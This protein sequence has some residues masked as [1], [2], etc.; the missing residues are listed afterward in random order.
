MGYRDIYTDNVSEETGKYECPRCSY[1]NVHKGDKFCA[2]CGAYIEWKDGSPATF[3]DCDICHG[4][5]LYEHNFVD[6]IDNRDKISYKA[7]QMAGYEH[8]CD[9]CYRAATYVDWKAAIKEILESRT[10]RNRWKD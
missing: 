7:L 1:K 6:L 2:E 3:P 10:R 9:S 8:I 4:S 5:I